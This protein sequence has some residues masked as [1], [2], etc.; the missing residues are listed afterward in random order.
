MRCTIGEKWALKQMRDLNSE[1]TKQGLKICQ[2]L[3]KKLNKPVYYHLYQY[4]MSDNEQNSKCPKCG[5]EWR[6]D[7][8]LHDQYDF[9]CDQC[10]LLSNLGYSERD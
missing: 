7:K 6:L 4:Y 3:M 2:K 5:G 9:K 10:Y 1:L 8:P